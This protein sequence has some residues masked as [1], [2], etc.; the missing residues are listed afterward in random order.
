[1]S[2]NQFRAGAEEVTR[3]KAIHA[4]NSGQ[5]IEPNGSGSFFFPKT[6]SSFG[7]SRHMFYRQS[8]LYIEW[9]HNNDQLSFKN[10]LLRLRK[11]DT[12]EQAMQNTYGYGVKE[13]WNHFVADIKISQ[14]ACSDAIRCASF[15]PHSSTIMCKKISKLK[16]CTRINIKK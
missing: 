13:G 2:Q 7:I 1:M 5:S 12:V 11:G 15:T 9:L 16:I 6:A 10:L 14:G 8:S 3:S 4:I